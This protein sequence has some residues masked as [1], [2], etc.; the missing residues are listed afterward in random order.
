MNL[1]ILFEAGNQTKNETLHNIGWQH[2][3]RTMY[4]HFRED[5]G[6]YHVVEYNETDGSVIRKHTA[7]GNKESMFVY[8][9]N[10]VLL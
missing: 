6:T 7:Q 4:E 1:E 10:C 8:I 9:A 3:N 2:T 5:N